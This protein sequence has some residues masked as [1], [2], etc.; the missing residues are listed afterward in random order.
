M[1]VCTYVC[2]FERHLSLP[3]VLI[4]FWFKA[5]VSNSA[6]PVW[7]WFRQD[8]LFGWGPT[9][10]QWGSAQWCEGRSQVDD[11]GLQ[12]PP[13]SAWHHPVALLGC[14]CC[15]WSFT[16]K[17]IYKAGFRTCWRQRSSIEQ[18]PWVSW[19]RPWNWCYY[20]A[21]SLCQIFSSCG[22]D[23]QSG[24]ILLSCLMGAC[25]L[26]FYLGPRQ[27]FPLWQTCLLPVLRVPVLMRQS[28][29]AWL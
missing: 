29:A 19:H 13:H 24:S 28:S 6:P 2:V 26:T 3:E 15:L 14:S 1:R 8:G 27:C 7:T 5:S 23:L 22:L 18:D 4:S 17:E 20:I 9:A 11:S 25:W 16:T 10:I 12:E 21:A